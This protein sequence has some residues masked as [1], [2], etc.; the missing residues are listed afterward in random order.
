M[1]ISKLRQ[2]AVKMRLDRYVD[3][4]RDVLI[5]AIKNRQA[6]E[7]E[8]EEEEEEGEEGGEEEE[9]GEEGEEAGLTLEAEVHEEVRRMDP[10]LGQ[11]WIH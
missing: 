4:S 3:G 5:G 10:R 6:E 8:E 2:L 1:Y 11:P 9:E 7:E